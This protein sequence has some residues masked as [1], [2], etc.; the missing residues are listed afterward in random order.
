MNSTEARPNRKHAFEQQT[1]KPTPLP[2][3]PEGIPATM[4]ARSQ[5]VVWRYEWKEKDDGSGRW[6]K[7]PFQ[8]KCPEFCADST[9]AS[10][11]AT[12]S[13]AMTTYQRGGFDGIGYVLNS[14]EAGID[15]DD[16]RDP[17]TGAID[18]SAAEIVNQIG[19][20]AEISPSGTGIKIVAKGTLQK[21]RKFTQIGVE[22][23]GRGR[24]FTVTGH[25]ISELPAVEDRQAE[26]DGIY[27]TLDERNDAAKQTKNDAAKQTKSR[28]KLHVPLTPSANLTDEDLIAKA[29]AAAG[30]AGKKFRDFMKGG[31]N[32][33]SSP[34]EADLAF[35][36]LIVFWTDDADQVRRIV[37]QSGLN[38]DKW[39]RD[40]Y[41]E[42]TIAL[43]FKG[44][45]NRY[46]PAHYFSGQ[47][48]HERSGEQN[49]GNDEHRGDAWEGEPLDH[50]VSDA[51]LDQAPPPD[52]APE[53]SEPPPESRP[54]EAIQLTD[55]GNG[56]RFAT[57]HREIVR[58]C[59]VW[60]CFVI[61]D[62]TRW[63][64]D[65]TGRAM[66]LAKQTITRLY[67]WAKKQIELLAKDESAEAA[68]RV[69]KI[70]VVLD[71]ALKSQHVNR[72]KAMLELAQSEPGIPILP[73]D[74]D[75]DPMLLNVANGTIDL[76]AGELRPHRQEDHITKIAPVKFDP[77]ATCPIWER[78]LIQ[79]HAGKKDMIGF[80]HRAVGYS[81]TGSVDEQCL[82]FLHGD[83]QN[84]KS[85]FLGALQKIL[86]DYAIQAVPEL[87][88]KKS[89]ETHP[90]ERADL[91]GVRFAATIETED[92]KKL[93]EALMKQLTGGDR[94][95]ARKMR[96][97]FFEFD[98]SAKIWFAANH[99][100]R[101]TGT[102]FAVWRR[103]KLVP[104]IVTISEDE[105]DGQLKE[106][107]VEEAPGI[108]N[109]CI[110]G[111]LDWQRDG[112][113]EPAEVKAAVEGYRSEQDKVGQFL[114]ECC[115]RG[116]DYRVRKS[117]LYALFKKWSEANGEAAMNGTAFGLAI[118]KHG[119]SI[120][121]GKRWYLSVA[122]Q[123]TEG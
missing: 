80:L 27:K 25:V 11:W 20:Y 68:L 108:L 15:L 66:A 100:P 74:L 9:K 3:M 90:T 97:D 87:L 105:K 111:C 10:T 102:D 114:L 39:K 88:T 79:W 14:D 58:Y 98:M 91:F 69:K 29:S 82:F 78:S 24:Y 30:D 75:R 104:F 36:N 77:T 26:I 62:G 85:T 94:V 57:D 32:G 2:V 8:A 4:K 45:R 93:A 18:P 43:A 40:D 67:A 113:A 72:L 116:H 7:P 103:I 83:G 84:G 64:P 21:G 81:L 22:M 23:Y 92:G 56:R 60:K 54:V 44:R 99:K 19:S 41:A 61:W 86:G 106:K 120:D 55:L 48:S 35:C 46:D 110:Q 96:K 121:N 89:N 70:K 28:F 95:R 34:S 13:E 17:V 33:Y 6:D 112:L 122:I 47:T 119:I 42:R 51:I 38:R 117:D 53:M 123:P 115:K 37:K 73:S 76:R 1:T 63:K 16:V 59:F 5:W 31:I 52:D 49:D 101:V 118:G 65:D 109:W 71:F 12:F 107:L 50:G